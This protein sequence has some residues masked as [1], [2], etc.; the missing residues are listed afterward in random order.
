MSVNSLV[1]GRDTSALLQDWHS[2]ANLIDHTLLTPAATGGA[3]IKLCSEAK[4]YGFFSVMVNPAWVAVA[5]AQVHGADLHQRTVDLRTSRS[6]SSPRPKQR[7]RTARMNSTWLSTSE[8]LKAATACW[9]RPKF[10][11]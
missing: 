2:V 5:A 10:A 6:P 4:R 3:V 8:R 9:C 7:C 11:V 1:M